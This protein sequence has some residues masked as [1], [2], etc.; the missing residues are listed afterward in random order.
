[1]VGKKS[2]ASLC[3]LGTRGR[4]SA[5]DLSQRVHDCPCGC[6]LDR[7]VAAAQVMLNWAKGVGTSLSNRGAEASTS[8]PTCC[9]G[10]KQASAKK[11]QKPLA[12]A[13]RRLG[14]SSFKFITRM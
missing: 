13:A 12:R 8:T 3:P 11:R 1:M 7:D 6:L 10:F 5:R 9:G 4:D 2:R 14:C